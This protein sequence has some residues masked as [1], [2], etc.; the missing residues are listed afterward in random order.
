MDGLTMAHVL[1]HLVLLISSLALLIFLLVSVCLVLEQ[2]Y[3]HGWWLLSLGT[4]SG[5]VYGISGIA[6]H[7]TGIPVY[8]LI[9]EGASLFFIL[10]LALGIRSF[11]FLGKTERDRPE[12][13]TW[14][15]WLDYRVWF[16]Y[17]VVGLFVAAWWAP[18]LA[19]DQVGSL[20]VQGVGWVGALLLA[21]V[22]G[23]LVVDRFEGSILSGLVRRLLPAVLCFGMIVLV[24]LLHLATG[25]L[26]SLL[27]AVWIVG[28]VLVGAFLFNTAVSVRQR[29]RE[30]REV[31]RRAF[32]GHL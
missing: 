4:G 1:S 30:L 26:G 10:F 6:Y 32:L 12:L 9:R 19:G 22:Y 3:R 29:H 16:D 17:A 2:T 14:N 21:L 11:Y 25:S 23:Y 7:L 20:I 24:E 5:V 8:D 28:I 15:V 13:P 18:F 31:H 27:E